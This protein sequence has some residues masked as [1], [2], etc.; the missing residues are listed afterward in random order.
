MEAQAADA[1]KDQLE[2]ELRQVLSRYPEMHSD[3][4][5][6]FLAGDGASEDVLR[7][8]LTQ[9]GD[10]M[11]AGRGATAGVKRLWAEHESK[12]GAGNFVG[13]ER[14]EGGL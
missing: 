3:V 5:E 7:K 6:E 4:T 10:R 14:S 13:G 8:V 2:E 1:I 11:R 12:R 9:P